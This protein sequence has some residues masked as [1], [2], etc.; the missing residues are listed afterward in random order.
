MV[1]RGICARGATLDKP[2]TSRNMRCGRSDGVGMSLHWLG[3][4]SR[5]WGSQPVCHCSVCQL[6][7]RW[8]VRASPGILFNG[9]IRQYGRE[10]DK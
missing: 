9:S 2:V 3:R 4:A 10:C 1:V 5:D 8:R 7:T 6:E